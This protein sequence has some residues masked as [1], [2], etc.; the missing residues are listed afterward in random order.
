MSD[1]FVKVSPVDERRIVG[2]AEAHRLARGPAAPPSPTDTAVNRMALGTATDFD[3]PIEERRSQPR[4]AFTA[5]AEV[6]DM[7]SRTR[8]NTRISDLG[9][10]G[11]YVDTNSPFPLKTRVRIRIISAKRTFETLGVV[12]YS[13]PNMGMGISF[14]EPEPLQ[15]VILK[16]WIDELS[17]ASVADFEPSEHDASS[18][19][20]SAH[21]DAQVH[22][23]QELIVALMRKNTLSE[24]EGKALLLHLAR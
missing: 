17:G 4:Y 11:C 19:A 20:E 5:T 16:A 12:V 2:S 7:V 9:M 14:A 3:V 10:E 6:V 21:K 8:M 15:H 22:V 24:S 13:L 1:D 18:S 23:L